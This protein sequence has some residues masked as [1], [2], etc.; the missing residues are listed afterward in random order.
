MALKGFLALVD[1]KL[2]EAFHYVA[3]DK[4]KHRKPFIA[5]LDK[6]KAQFDDDK[7]PRGD[8][9]M[10]SIN[11]KVVHFT[12]KL[13]ANP[14]K[15]HEGKSAFFIPS[16]RFPNALAELRKDVEAGELDSELHEAAEGDLLAGGVKLSGHRVERSDKPARAGWSPE[17]RAKY[18]ATQAAKKGG[19][20]A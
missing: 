12:P 6:A 10:W 1:E 16:E 13:G 14:V 19:K 4:T 8:K 5:A 17:R 7:P 2:S 15:I 20:P 9:A 11:N 18:E 3:P